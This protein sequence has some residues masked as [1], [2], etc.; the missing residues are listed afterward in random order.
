MARE[1]SESARANAQRL[2]DMYNAYLTALDTLRQD[3]TRR[4]ITMD[5]GAW[6]RYGAPALENFAKDLS[7]AV[8]CISRPTHAQLEQDSP[9]YREAYAGAL[10]QIL[11]L[12]GRY[13]ADDLSGA[14]AGSINQAMVKE[15]EA[16]A[17]KLQGDVL[18]VSKRLGKARTDAVNKAVADMDGE[19]AVQAMLGLIGYLD[20][21]KYGVE[22]H[23][24]ALRDRPDIYGETGHETYMRLMLSAK[25]VLGDKKLARM[26]A[27]TRRNEVLNVAK[28]V[29]DYASKPQSRW[30]WSRPTAAGDDQSRIEGV[31]SL[32]SSYGTMHKENMA[33]LSK[34]GGIE[35]SGV[36]PEQLGTSALYNDTAIWNSMISL[37]KVVGN[38]LPMLEDALIGGDRNQ[39]LS[40]LSTTNMDVNQAASYVDTILGCRQEGEL[41]AQYVRQMKAKSYRD[42]LE[43][44]AGYIN[45]GKEG[46]RDTR[47]S[48][49]WEDDGEFRAALKEVD[50]YMAVKEA[51]GGGSGSSGSFA[52]TWAML[53]GDPALVDAFIRAEPGVADH[54]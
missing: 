20:Q 44:L 32:T 49:Y 39:V 27:P 51:M 6:E 7:N 31:E 22:N 23:L 14:A 42:Y 8:W 24:Q 41:I 26:Y 40:L 46:T 19:E 36:S 2:V 5:A 18:A 17:K 43:F 54:M 34:A 30:P 38:K 9:G 1:I 50:E 33:R 47:M 25:K 29:N 10:L 21:G 4:L 52:N 12:D 35:G 37:S 15:I 48:P 28:R 45:Y 13:T 11:G 53:G 3:D 16:G